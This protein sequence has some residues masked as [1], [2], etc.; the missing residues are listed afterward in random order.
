MMVMMHQSFSM[1]QMLATFENNEGVTISKP[2]RRQLMPKKQLSLQ[3]KVPVRL[4]LPPYFTDLSGMVR[5][6]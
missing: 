6:D 4:F 3:Q 2:C 5:N 1:L